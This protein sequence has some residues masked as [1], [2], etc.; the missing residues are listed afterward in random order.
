MALLCFDLDGTL[1][2]PLEG[3]HTCLRATCMDFGIPCPDLDRIVEVVG[4]DLEVL[5]WDLPNPRRHEVMERYWRLFGEEGVFAQRIH[6]GAHLMLARLKR[7]GHRLCLVTN[8][9]AAIARRTLH[10]FDLIL[11]FDDVIGLTATESWKTKEVIMAR[12]QQDGMLESSGYLIGD[13]ADD[14]RAAKAHG[15]KALGVTYGF[16][17][18]QELLKAKADILLDSMQALDGWLVKELREPEIHDPFSRS[19]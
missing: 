19:E 2:D 5:F 16:G 7:Q 13:R 6:S 8:Q 15:L 12:L 3:M 11:S 10:H 18:R 4:L 1:V 9:S 17:K 14:M